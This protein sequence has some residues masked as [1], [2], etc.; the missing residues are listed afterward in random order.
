MSR[1]HQGTDRCLM[2]KRIT[3]IAAMG[4]NHA[5]GLDGA[6]PWHLPAE[7]Q[8]FK[9]A[10]MNKAIL[11]TGVLVFITGQVAFDDTFKRIGAALVNRL[12]C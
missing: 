1:R 12:W 11:T 9:Q 8:H 6:M 10:T 4:K 3:L 5:I 2:R 7:L